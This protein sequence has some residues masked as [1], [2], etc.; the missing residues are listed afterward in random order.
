MTCTHGLTRPGHRAVWGS[1]VEI[2]MI[3][4]HH[5]GHVHSHGPA[6]AAER[7][8]HGPGELAVGLKH[9]IPPADSEGGPS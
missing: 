3:E 8:D 4:L 1:V 2:A 7:F 5:A 6:T 9:D